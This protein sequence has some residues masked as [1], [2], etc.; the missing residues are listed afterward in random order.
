MNVGYSGYMN[1]YEEV[2]YYPYE[3]VEEKEIV[4]D[5][6]EEVSGVDINIP[7]GWTE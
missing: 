6:P 4:V 3:R 2:P 1:V 5:A 7:F